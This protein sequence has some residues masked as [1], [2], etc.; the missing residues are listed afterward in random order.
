M[1][2]GVRWGGEGRGEN[3]GGWMWNVEAGRGGGFDGRFVLVLESVVVGGVFIVIFIDTPRRK[4]ILSI[5][6]RS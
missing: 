6:Q 1:E 4:R 3:G 2:G 5:P